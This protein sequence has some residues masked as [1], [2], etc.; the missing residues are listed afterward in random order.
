[1]EGILQKVKKEYNNRIDIA[2]A[3]YH[4]LFKLNG[5]PVS[6]MELELVCHCA[7][8]GTISYSTS[9]DEFMKKFGVPK[10]SIYNMISKLQRRKIFM[11]ID[12]LTK[13][14]PAIMLDFSKPF[15][16]MELIMINKEGH[17]TKGSAE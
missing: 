9:R 15:I 12:G 1:M 14:N 5:I 11:K 4:I 3:Y 2:K 7:V 16:K 17:E 8:Y 10:A 13:V 6:N